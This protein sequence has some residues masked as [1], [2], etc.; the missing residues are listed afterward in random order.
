MPKKT[1]YI[2]NIFLLLAVLTA[3]A[4]SYFLLQSS[5][6]NADENRAAIFFNPNYN[7]IN[8]N[9]S[10]PLFDNPRTAVDNFGWQ[11]VVWSQYS[12]VTPNIYYKLFDN[13]GQEYASGDILVNDTTY[14]GHFQPDVATVTLST[15]TDHFATVS[16]VG[17]GGNGG[18][19]VWIQNYFNE[20]NSGSNEQVNS[21]TLPAIFEQ[22]IAIDPDDQLTP[23][24]SRGVVVWRT[25]D[26]IYYQLIDAG[27]NLATTNLIG[28]ENILDS[29]STYTS[30]NDV[31]VAMNSNGEYIIAWIGQRDTDT[32]PKIYYQ[33]FPSYNGSGGAPDGSP[34]SSMSAPVSI[35]LQ[36]TE[37]DVAADKHAMTG[38]NDDSQRV[39]YLTYAK[40]RTVTTYEDIVVRTINCTDPDPALNDNTDLNC[41]LET[42]QI[43]ASEDS[44]E[45]RKSPSIDADALANFTVTWNEET[46]TPGIILAASYNNKKQL[47]GGDV[48]TPDFNT[49]DITGPVPA[50]GW[51]D[52]GM[53]AFGEFNIVYPTNPNEILNRYFINET[54]K[55]GDEEYAVFDDTNPSSHGDSDIAPNGNHVHVW[56]EPI[57]DSILFTLRPADAS[58]PAIKLAEAVPSGTGTSRDPLVAF[59][60]DETGA[61]VGSFVIA[62]QNTQDG[63]YDVFYKIY[64]ANGDTDASPAQKANDLTDDEQFLGGL[65]TG[66][67]YQNGDDNGGT[68]P[69][70]EEFVIVWDDSNLT[71]QIRAAHHHLVEYSGNTNQ[72][73][74]I[75]IDDSTFDSY[76]KSYPSVFINTESNPSEI[77][78]IIA[79]QWDGFGKI[80]MREFIN[81]STGPIETPYNI[82]TISTPDTLLYPKVAPVN[83]NIFAL[84]YND[85]NDNTTH[86]GFYNYSNAGD[87]TELNAPVNVFSK[88]GTLR[89]DLVGNIDEETVAIT[90]YNI[91]STLGVNTIMAKFYKKTGSEIVSTDIETI[92][93]STR[94]SNSIVLPSIGMNK[95][96]K[97]VISYEGPY[98]PL[99][100]SSPELSSSINYQLLQNPYIISTPD[101]YTPT[102]SQNVTAGGLSMI[103]P[104]SITFL[105]SQID[106]ENSA[107]SQV[108]IRSTATDDACNGT[109]CGT[110]TCEGNTCGGDIP[111]IQIHDETGTNFSLS[112]AITDFFSKETGA[113]SIPKDNI[114]IRNYD[115]DNENWETNADCGTDPLKCFSVLFSSLS[116]AD[117]GFRLSSVSN[118]FAN[119]DS[120]GQIE[121]A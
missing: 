66:F 52:I 67:Y 25:N 80:A 26:T 2:K 72:L 109:P 33:I 97:T 20:I 91:N 114:E 74:Q 64:D 102:A 54:F 100:L 58:E 106:L 10:D 90:D 23:S 57:S 105:P 101:D 42:N 93:N 120:N 21:T 111:Y 32:Y 49:Y 84:A 43:I 92:V 75:R 16:W 88:E 98:N 116:L 48:F 68:N 86:M 73:T 8:S 69:A 37:L 12:G 81:P 24:Y 63:P 34:I 96:G 108:S 38:P 71:G 4:S 56:R 28:S 87:I 103:V 82:Y 46:S 60:K 76:S 104:T 78:G 119:L 113:I 19:D 117:T 13:S 41:N 55:I 18:D 3:I 1:R 89:N 77:S 17:N 31:A 65:D 110:V 30:I 61:G 44:D 39:F 95:S 9:N 45:N 118:N 59:F 70:I 85:Y 107:T 40:P 121:L 62:W 27:Y 35:D 79:W 47:I 115:F 29:T 6:F 50:Q 53:N 14:Q 22:H 5:I 51:P 83:N 112:F 7:Y 11:S 15:Y 99:N 36:A 94:N